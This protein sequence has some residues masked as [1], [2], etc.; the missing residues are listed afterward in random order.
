[1]TEFLISM[2]VVVICAMLYN[3]ILDKLGLKEKTR[4][5]LILQDIKIY[6]P[7]HIIFCTLPFLYFSYHPSL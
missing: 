6:L 4:Q 1:M 7:N 5:Y 2:A 3:K